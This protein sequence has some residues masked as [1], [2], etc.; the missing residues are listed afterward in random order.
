MFKRFQK[1]FWLYPAVMALVV[2]FVSAIG[3]TASA[4]DYKDS[5]GK[6][7]MISVW[8]DNGGVLVQLNPMHSTAGLS[9]TSNYWLILR[10]SQEG[11]ETALSLLTSA[12]LADREVTVRAKEGGDPR[13][14]ELGR[15]VLH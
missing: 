11:Y 7:A 8:T 14:C 12:K 15:V 1:R 3:S 6:V 5:K 10:P 13:F 9:C 4:A 2:C